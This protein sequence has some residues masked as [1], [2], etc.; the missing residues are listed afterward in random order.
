MS[1]IVISATPSVEP[2][3]VKSFMHHPVFFLSGYLYK[4]YRVR[5][6]DLSP[7]VASDADR[8][9]A[10]VVAGHDA[11]LRQALQHLRPA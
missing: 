5:Y 3:A 2:P 9:R 1:I 10:A 7:P 6:N 11:G 4:I 8:V